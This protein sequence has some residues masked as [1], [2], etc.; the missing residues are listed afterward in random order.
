MLL[1]EAGETYKAVRGR[2]TVVGL[3]FF[4]KESRVKK[5]WWLEDAM[6]YGTRRE[7]PIDC[8]VTATTVRVRV[9]FQLSTNI[10]WWQKDV[11]PVWTG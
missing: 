10:E 11:V 8:I 1:L 5:G 4:E 9:D 6:T 3:G 2:N 7:L